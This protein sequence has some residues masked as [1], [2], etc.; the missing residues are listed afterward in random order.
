MSDLQVRLVSFFPTDYSI[1]RLLGRLSRPPRNRWEIAAE[2]ALE[3]SVRNFSIA[4]LKDSYVGVAIFILLG[5]RV[6]ARTSA[7]V[8]VAQSVWWKWWRL[9]HLMF[10]CCPDQK[11]ERILLVQRVVLVSTRAEKSVVCYIKQNQMH[12]FLL[13][14]L[15]H[16]SSWEFRA[17]SCPTQLESWADL[18]PPYG[19]AIS[20][21]GQP[22]SKHSW[23]L[24]PQRRA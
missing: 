6:R 14:I 23:L 16:K 24:E 5:W 17:C 18:R 9:L 3:A 1:W 4:G 22:A 8:M 19:K 10:D 13:G 12:A 21:L 11:S 15:V 2:I 7:D 20:V